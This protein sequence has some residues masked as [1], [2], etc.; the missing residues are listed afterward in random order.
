METCRFC[1][2]G[3]KIKADFHDYHKNSNMTA[4]I[5]TMYI[6]DVKHAR[7]KLAVAVELVNGKLVLDDYPILPW[8]FIFDIEFCPL[9]GRP[10]S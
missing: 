1:E 2:G 3:E 4:L 10:L 5:A 7:N 9:C 8:E 6:A